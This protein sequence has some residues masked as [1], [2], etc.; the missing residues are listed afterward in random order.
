MYMVYGTVYW[1]NSFVDKEED[2]EDNAFLY[3]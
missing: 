1:T 2:F 3:R